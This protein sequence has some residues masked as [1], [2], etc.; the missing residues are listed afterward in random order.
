MSSR[1]SKQFV[2]HRHRGYGTDH[3]DLMLEEEGTLATWRLDR[4]LV[5]GDRATI[6]AR[7]IQDHRKAYLA[8]EGE[9]RQGRGHVEIVDAGSYETLAREEER[10]HV[11]LIGRRFAGE[12]IL[13]HLGGRAGSADRWRVTPLANES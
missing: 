6:R 2:L 11:R 4:P 7:R 13:S 12:V 9:V 8:Y 3:W 5:P 10:W 1:T